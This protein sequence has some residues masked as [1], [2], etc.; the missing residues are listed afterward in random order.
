MYEKL[1]SYYYLL[2]LILYLFLDICHKTEPLAVNAFEKISGWMRLKVN[3]QRSYDIIAEIIV[4]SDA[5]AKSMLSDPQADWVKKSFAS[6]GA[7]E[8]LGDA[9]TADPRT[10]PDAGRRRRGRWALH[11]Q[12]YWYEH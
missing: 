10:E 12:T 6:I 7:E 9:D 2:I 5:T 8:N 3:S 4:C 1:N 11:E